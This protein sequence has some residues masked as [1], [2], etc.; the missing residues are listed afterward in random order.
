MNNLQSAL[1]ASAMFLAFGSTA[2]GAPLSK[3]EYKSEKEAIS[4][5]YSADKAA[6]DSKGDNAKDICI[7]EAKG[8]G[9][10]AKA[11]LEAKYEPSVKHHYEVR[12]AKADAAYEVAKEKCDDMAGNARDVCRKEAKA[13][14][15]SAKADA[16]VAEKT[17]D[18]NTAA[19]EKTSEANM[20][21]QDKTSSARKDA[22]SD[23]RDA[24][25]AVAKEKCD[26][27]SGDP[28]AACIKDAKSHYGQ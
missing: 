17:S 21:A 24:G 16:K 3:A 7:E 6:C 14:H 27:L 2:I 19:R 10:I 5:Q 25:Y 18:A 22:A 13:A 11:E 12:L 8:R 26:A 23:K 20:A 1:L 15:V 4:R 9:N 28:K